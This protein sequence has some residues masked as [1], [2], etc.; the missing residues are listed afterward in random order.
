MITA[1]LVSHQIQSNTKEAFSLQEKSQFGERDHDQIL[2]LPAEALFLLK[3]KKLTLVKNSKPLSVEQSM[4][5]LKKLDSRLAL[6]Y[7][8]YEDLR[9][10]GFVL[11][12]G[13]KFGGDFRVYP[14]GSQPGKEH[15]QWI[16]ICY[17][18]SQKVNWHEFSSK[19]RVAHSTNKKVLFALVDQENKPNY[20]EVAWR[21][22]Q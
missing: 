22:L 7:P 4:L 19:N 13:L 2:Y 9:K 18:E 21:K 14:R 15:A 11:K 1:N 12:T 8:V 5:A 3:R 17:Q 16:L 6:T 10:K 20:Y